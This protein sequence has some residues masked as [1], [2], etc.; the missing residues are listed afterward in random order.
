VI[1]VHR[2]LRTLLCSLAVAAGVAA[3]MAAAT[4]APAHA[5]S[6]AKTCTVPRG[7]KVAKKTATVVVY[8]Y[9]KR[10]REAGPGRAWVACSK[11]AGKR[12]ALGFVAD[13]PCTTLDAVE[14][15][16]LAGKYLA[17]VTETTD[18][19]GDSG[20]AFV[21]L[22]DLEAARQVALDPVTTDSEPSSVNLT[23]L[24]LR[25]DG[26]LAWIVKLDNDYARISSW[27][28]YASDSSGTRAL[29][30]SDGQPSG[31]AMSD[32]SV[33]WTNDGQPRTAPLGPGPAVN[34][35]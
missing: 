19:T 35:N 12:I 5:A 9:R 14:G 26:A 31:L 22:V 16:R 15:L 17:Y 13:E 32:T 4:T 33:G 2:P 28:V 1:T 7:A 30:S 3:G 25:A 18:C 27:Y 11:L 8:S 23:E 21:S 20:N 10:D 29:E 34:G 24:A 6:A